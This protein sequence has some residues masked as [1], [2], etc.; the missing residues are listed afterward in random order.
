MDAELKAKWVKALRSGE[1]EQC[2]GDLSDGIGFCCIGVG[3]QLTGHDCDEV[4]ESDDPTGVAAQ[5]IGLSPTEEGVLVRMN[6]GDEKMRPHA[7]SEI[8]DYIERNL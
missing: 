1:F 7:F 4:I 3:Y 8:A 6:D 2:R 5:A